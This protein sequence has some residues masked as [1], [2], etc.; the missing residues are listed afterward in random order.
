MRVLITLS[1]LIYREAVA[2]S[3]RQRRPGFEVR[4]A[5]PEAVEEKVRA[6]RPHLLARTCSCATTQMG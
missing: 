3:V 1:P 2:Q 4:I 6:F 5:S